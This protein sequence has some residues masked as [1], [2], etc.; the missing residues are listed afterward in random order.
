M[1]KN[2]DNK[3]LIS[4]IVPVYNAERC[5][6]KCLKSILGQSYENYEVVIINDG[7]FDHSQ[8]IC[9]SFSNLDPRIRL[10][11]KQN[12]GVSSAR[13][14]GLKAVTGDYICFVDADD[15]LEPDYLS[16]FVNA[17]DY[18]SSLIIQD[19]FTDINEGSIKN[20][21]LPSCSYLRKDFNLFFRKLELLRNGYSWSKLYSRKLIDARGIY[22]NSD[23]SFA[24]DCLFLLEYLK[25]VDQVK[26]IGYAGYHYTHENPTS[27]SKTHNS[28]KSELT[29]Y[30]SLKQCVNELKLVYHFDA[31]AEVYTNTLLAKFFLRSIQSAY[32]GTVAIS[33]KERIVAQRNAYSVYD[34]NLLSILNLSNISLYTW[35][36]VWLFR[37]KM[38]Y[39]YDFYM[40]LFMLVRS[41]KRFRI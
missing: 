38:F 39:G 34:P 33:I 20:F 18:T 29:A 11:N 40:N 22:F 5:I 3:P 27:L 7:S 16:Q 26:F 12:G 23:V 37:C 30:C 15:W 1:T 6:S 8:T 31:E 9:E 17:I 36:S 19:H 21:N 41:V 2:K 24:E 13:N 28:S 14:L 10:I 35:I 4:L 25:Y 32:R